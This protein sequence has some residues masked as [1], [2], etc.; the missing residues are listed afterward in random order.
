[1]ASVVYPVL[2][3]GVDLR[4]AED[5]EDFVQVRWAIA[6]REEEQPVVTPAALDGL[7]FPAGVY[8]FHFSAELYHFVWDTFSD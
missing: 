3:R 5:W 8:T 4:D 2:A 1:M 6:G 7:S